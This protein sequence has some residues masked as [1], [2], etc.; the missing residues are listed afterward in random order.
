MDQ[1][2]SAALSSPRVDLP[3]TDLQ[4]TAKLSFVYSLQ[5]SKV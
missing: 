2:L 3:L 1:T 4:L 5:F